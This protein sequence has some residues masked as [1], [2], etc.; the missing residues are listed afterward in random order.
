MR[1]KEKIFHCED[2]QAVK[3]GGCAVS[4]LSGRIFKT[5][6]DKPQ[7]TWSEACLVLCRSLSQRPPDR[8]HLSHSVILITSPSILLNIMA[9]L[10]SSLHLSHHPKQPL[11]ELLTSRKKCVSLQ[12]PCNI[13]ICLRNKPWNVDLNI[14]SRVTAELWRVWNNGFNS[15]IFPTCVVLSLKSPALG[16]PVLLRVS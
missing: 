2:S 8:F 7:A 15:E 10:H 13:I 16:P 12:D 14:F 5:Q 4:L 3:Q 6:L 11:H 1:F 9:A